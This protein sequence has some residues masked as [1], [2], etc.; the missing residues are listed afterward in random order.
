MTELA[1]AENVVC[2]ISALGSADPHWTAASIRPWVLG[3]VEAF[4]AD[5][6]MLATNWPVDKLFGTYE[7]LL[8]AYVE[9]ATELTPSEQQAIFSATAERVHRI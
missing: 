7:R 3:C 5:R 8:S 1:T 9:I 2:K 4:G 6:C